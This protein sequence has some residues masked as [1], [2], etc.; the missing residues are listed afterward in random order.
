MTSGVYIITNMLNMHQYIGSAVNISHRF[1]DHRKGRNSN[2][3]LQRAIKKYGI[4]NFEFDVLEECKPKDNL[5]TEQYYLDLYRPEYND[6][7]IAGSM[8]GYRYTAAQ[9]AKMLG[10][11]LSEKAKVK[12]G[13]ASSKRMLG[14]KF[15]EEAKAKMSAA[16]KG[17][18]LTAE[19]K[20]KLSAALMGNKHLLG[21]HWKCSEEIKLKLSV[22]KI[23]NKSWLGRKHTEEEKAK[24]GAATK[25]RYKNLKEAHNDKV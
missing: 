24:I 18:K 4:E 15:S 5:V 20:A 9:R 3:H 17:Q 16:K 7:P 12:I 10:R 21:K 25:L 14:Y 11:K 23:G 19:H 2:L 8:L 13:A 6:A 22:S 1:Y